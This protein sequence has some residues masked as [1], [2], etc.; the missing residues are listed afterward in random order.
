MLIIMST[1]CNMEEYPKLA[2]NVKSALLE[3]GYRINPLII[4]QKS[5]LQDRQKEWKSQ[6]RNA[7]AQDDTISL[8]FIYPLWK[9]NLQG[10]LPSL[11]Q[12]LREEFNYQGCIHISAVGE[13][14]MGNNEHISTELELSKRKNHIS[15][16]QHN[17]AQMSDKN[18]QF[19]YLS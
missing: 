4:Q 18:I 3:E 15:N 11:C 9:T 8:N 6:L 16:W 19:Q 7:L 10:E 2:I 14:I 5:F 12:E 1:D 13:R 17:I